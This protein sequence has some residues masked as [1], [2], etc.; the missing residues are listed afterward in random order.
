M[1]YK[2]KDKEEGL[3]IVTTKKK[4]KKVKWNELSY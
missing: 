3:Q 2:K 4:Q 1:I